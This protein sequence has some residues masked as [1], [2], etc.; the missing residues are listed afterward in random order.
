MERNRLGVTIRDALALDEFAGTKVVAGNNSLDRKIFHI[1]VMEV[2]DILDWVREGEL[3]F[4]TLYSLRDSPEEQVALIP[5]LAEKKLAGLAIKPK[6]YIDQIPEEVINVANELEFPILQLGPHVAFATVMEPLLNAIF[7]FQTELLN[8]SEWVH[9]QLMEV[10]L[11]GGGLDKL[12]EVVGRLLEKEV[13][14]VDRDIEP[15]STMSPRMEGWI[16]SIYWPALRGKVS[17]IRMGGEEPGLIVPLMA[18]GSLL[19]YLVTSCCDKQSRDYS[20]LDEIAMERAATVATLDIINL[21]AREE[22]ERRFRNEFVVDLVEGAFSSDN[23]ARTRAKANNW[24]LGDDMQ[25][26]LLRLMDF[27]A[28]DQKDRLLRYLREYLGET[29]ITGELGRDILLIAPGDDESFRVRKWLE[30][31]LS[32]LEASA[33]SKLIIG[34]GRRSSNI[35]NVKYS[36]RQARRT[37]KTAEQVPSLGRLVYYD[38][39]GIYRLLEELNGK[40]EMQSFIS[41][42][43]QILIDYDEKNNTDLLNTLRRYYIWGG[44][45]KQVSEELFV[46]Y[47][48]VLY[49]IKRI[50]G[51][52]GI[53]L[54][55]PQ[56]R[57]TIEV[58]IKALDFK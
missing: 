51:L 41:D 49:R 42:T 46:H 45:L 10:V 54:D 34:A 37:V 50:E 33:S 53:S 7:D 28:Q 3:L 57:L 21:R 24:V 2:P 16:N 55:D 43:L 4:T 11:Q 1:N 6:R 35:R 8:R 40:P 56:Q 30:L 48:T 58:A 44:N 18:G 32:Q 15:L 27:R 25:V 17:L 14:I 29:C 38:D 23:V 9:N 13:A 52:L 26:F 12:I 19:G 20:I 22:I 5:R 39:L 36:F 31:N 47:N